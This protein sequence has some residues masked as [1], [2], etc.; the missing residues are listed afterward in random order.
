MN[1]DFLL[2]D[3]FI[4]D[5]YID[6]I[7]FSNIGSQLSFTTSALF[8]I[9]RTFTISMG[10]GGGRFTILKN[11]IWFRES[12]FIFLFRRI[13]LTL[14]KVPAWSATTRLPS[15]FENQK[16]EQFF[17]ALIRSLFVVPFVH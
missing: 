15:I 5:T 8:I 16:V 4:I 1:Y 6:T 9:F 14:F 3:N 7:R 10:K 11:R 13:W 17:S 12:V 2:R